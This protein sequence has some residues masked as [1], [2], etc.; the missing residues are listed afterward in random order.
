MR[1]SMSCLCEELKSKGF[2]EI[3]CENN[4]RSFV[5]DFSGGEGYVGV[6]GGDD[7]KNVDCVVVLFDGREEW[8]SWILGGIGVEDL[9]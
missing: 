9:G 8:N 7:G 6:G 4:I 2:S 5:G 3:S 1:G